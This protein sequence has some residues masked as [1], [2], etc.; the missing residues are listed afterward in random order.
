[1][2]TFKWIRNTFMGMLLCLTTFLA[3]CAEKRLVTLFCPAITSLHAIPATRR[4]RRF[5]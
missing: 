1:M 4:N 2:I 5:G 3:G